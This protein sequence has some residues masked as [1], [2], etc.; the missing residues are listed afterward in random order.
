MVLC[1]LIGDSH[2]P[3]RAKDV[4]EII[5]NE[6]DEMT[7]EQLFDHTFFT[8]D[9]IKAPDFMKFLERRTEKNFFIVLGNMDY[10]YGNR[11]SP[12]YHELNILLNSNNKLNIGLIHGAQIRPRG[13]HSQ[14]ESLA[15]EKANNILISGHTHKEEV[16][17]TKKG[18]LLINP[19]S[20][21]GAWSFISSGIPS[22]S[23]IR[24]NKQNNDIQVS[25]YQLNTKNNEISKLDS[26]YIFENN[27]IH[28]KY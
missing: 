16:F 2:L 25:L 21:T 18:I 1:L 26:Y 10:Y 11:I 13:D 28:Y 9:A 17:L 3:Y 14:L 19:G 22:F 7:T 24:I 23:A 12:E 6:L 20:V 4:S 27:R 8:G 15:I 5:L